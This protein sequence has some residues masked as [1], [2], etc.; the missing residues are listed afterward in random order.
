MSDKRFNQLMW[1]AVSDDAS[2]VG[3]SLNG[4]RDAFAQIVRRYQSLV[5]SL[6]YC[7]TGNLSQSEDLAQETFI[8]AWNQLKSLRE[9]QK[10]PAWLSGIARRTT[11]NALRRQQRDPAEG[12]VPL[13]SLA[14]APALDAL[15]VEHAISREE[16][17][18]LWRSLEQIPDTYREPLILFYR[19]GQSIDRVAQALGLSQDAVRQRLARGRKLLEE[20]LAA[21]VEGALKQSAPGRSFTLGVMGMLP[22]Q[23]ASLGATSTGLLAK[24]SGWLAL[25]NACAGPL[26]AFVSNYLGY[27]MDMAGAR[28]QQERQ[29]IRRYYRLLAAC[30]LVPLAL[31]FV[32]VWAKPLAT[33][34]PGWFVALTIA[35]T[36]SW[37]PAVSLLL[38][39]AK[40]NLHNP[41][42]TPAEATPATAF[43]YRSKAS[44]LGLPL[45]HIRFGGSWTLRNRPVKAWIALGDR[46]IG[47]VFA[48]GAWA[49]APVCMGGL[50]V[51]GLTFGGFSLGVVVYAGFGM[52]LWAM[53]GL[54][55]GLSAI[56]GCALGWKAA[57][58]GIAVAHQ[59]AQGGVA[60]A[61]HANDTAADT[62]LRGSAFFQFTYLLLTKG[63]WPTMLLATLPS[64]LIWRATRKSRRHLS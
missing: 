25:L 31:I 24:A 53:G 44:L 40:R 54:V 36:L 19:E 12:A 33:S 28:S 62:Y 15:P 56:G 16:E 38:L 57:L 6:A 20:R 43:E 27:R 1:G 2:L 18:L 7:A 41:P 32:A 46:A 30:I 26:A 63:L 59:F 58:G 55:L 51:G 47:V 13:E 48:F 5:A 61:L 64:V 3:A 17:T 45:I 11:A 39:W 21:F 14:E 52:G 49:M 37:V 34:H 9:P 35:V 60:V 10:L 23:V 50:A 42:A 4:D 22:A 8:T 29:V